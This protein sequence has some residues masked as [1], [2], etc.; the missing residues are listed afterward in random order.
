MSD[1]IGHTKRVRSITTR[2]RGV[3]AGGPYSI[4]EWPT[5]YAVAVS[6]ELPPRNA[7]LVFWEEKDIEPDTEEL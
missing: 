5:Y 2:E 1:S 3:V 7:K 6:S 4:A